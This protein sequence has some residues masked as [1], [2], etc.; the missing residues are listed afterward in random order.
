MTD[1]AFGVAASERGRLA[2]MYGRPDV[3]GRGQT[4]MSIF[5]A[6]TRGENE[7]RDVPATSPADAPH[8][9]ARGG[10]G[11]CSTRGDLLRF[12]QMQLGEG[13]LDGTRVLAPETVR[14]MYR[15]HLP[16]ALLP[17]ESGGQPVVGYGF[18]L[19]SSVL[20]DPEAA[21]RAASA[22]THGWP[23]AAC[24]HYW[25]DPHQGVIGVLLAQSM[26]RMDA[27]DVALQALVYDAIVD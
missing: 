10:Y 21:G 25:V 5:D 17:W 15:N 26:M 23:G 18:G 4:A 6:W 16:A 8:V 24:T 14:L 11:L 7:R 12:A 13:E 9:F 27:P 1:T 2:A 3:L 20:M 19:G 22:G